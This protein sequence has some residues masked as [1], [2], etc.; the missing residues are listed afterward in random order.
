MGRRSERGV[1]AL[2][3][4]LLFSA[5]FAFF[6][7]AFNVGAMM[8]SRTQL[9]NGADSSA[10]AAAR[11]LN[12]MSS[13][14]TAAGT[15]ALVYSVQH[16]A[17]DQ[18]ITIDASGGGDVTFGR[19][20]FHPSECLFGASGSDCF[21]PLTSTD[22]H[23]ITAVKVRNG[24][25]GVGLHNP[26]LDLLFG[27]FVGTSQASVRSA[28]VATGGGPGITSCALPFAVADCAIVNA[29]GQVNSCAGGTTQ[30]LVFSNSN[31]DGIGFV[32]LYYPADTQ[33]PNN[34]FVADAIDNRQCNPNAYALGP[35]KV[36][37]GNDF[38]TKVIDALRG[39]DNKGNATAAGCMIGKTM[40]WAVIDAGC[41]DNPI[42]QGVLDV[43]GFVKATI[44]AVTD[45]Q[46]TSLGCPGSTPVA[47]DGAPMNAIVVDIP[48]SAPA[49][50]GDFGGGRSYNA[51]SVPT[52]LVE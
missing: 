38:N 40:S 48:C 5:V 2:T 14:L 47:V 1:A 12:G 7:L 32:N 49:D 20:H 29:S 25:D 13:G 9:Q 6:V 31:V 22:P 33:S 21:E 18:Q 28:A 27:Q 10:L 19:W 4:M 35:A 50:P 8:E 37:N 3:T 46:G 43:V 24:R 34:G 51:A 45:N 41:P 23:L 15:S 30:R 36:Q 42:F 39:L 52:R 16:I 26:P 17:Y 44:V 11:S